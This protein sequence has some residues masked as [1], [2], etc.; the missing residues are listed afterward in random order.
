M[1]EKTFELK[2]VDPISVG[3]VWGFMAAVFALIQVLIFYFATIKVP[4]FSG[5]GAFMIVAF[6][7]LFGAIGFV[8]GALGAFIYNIIALW[9]GGVKVDLEEE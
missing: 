9:V 3:K 7:L 4:Y 2:S 8:L 6:P 5:G 1:P